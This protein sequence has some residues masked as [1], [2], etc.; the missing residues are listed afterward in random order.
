MKP[1]SRPITLPSAALAA[2]VAPGNSGGRI[3]LLQVVGNAIVGGMEG[4]VE[5]LLER[6]PADRFVVTAL[7][8]FESPFTDRLRALGVDVVVT[9]MPEE[10]PWA[11]VQLAASL[12]AA[13]GIEL[14][15]AHLPNAHLLAGLVGR[16][17][18]RP[19]VTTIHG[20][21]V[22]LLDLE[23]HRAAG[24]HLSVVCQQSYFH[25][26]GLGVDPARLS[27]EPNGVDTAVFQ[28]RP[29][30][31]GGLRAALGLAPDTPLVGCVGRLSPEKG[32]EVFVRAALL[33]RTR[34]PQAHAV[35]IGEGPM[36]TVVQGLVTQYGLE[37]QFHLAGGRSDMP[38][39][40]NELDVMVGSSHSEAMPLAL[41]EAMAS[42]VPVVATR[43]GGVP[44]LVE[45]GHTGWL[46]GPGDFEDIGARCA[47]LLK[48]PALRAQMGQRARQRAVERLGLAASV[49][50]SADL[51]T[52]LARPEA[53]GERAA[54]HTSGANGQAKPTPSVRGSGNGQDHG[55]AAAA[56]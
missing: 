20:R 49:E 45:H 56:A 19:V 1:A 54:E 28:P 4:C 15:H 37:A 33:L 52:R 50:R 42:A 14:L 22:S 18:G 9:P 34:F 32:P 23:L 48:D 35:M 41:M 8:P 38:E 46:V 27:C 31:S 44:D 26:L 51:L 11:S 40:Y 2:N 36:R 16:L 47:G 13:R 53:L 21:Q 5:R 12:V 7:C 6:L 43:V 25:A 55:P 10:A 39:V 24:S 3:R 17:C 30:P 29:R